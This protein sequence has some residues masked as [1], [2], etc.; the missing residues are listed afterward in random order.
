MTEADK[1]PKTQASSKIGFIG[2]GRMA[3]A[4]W[5]GIHLAQIYTSENVRIYVR[6][7]AKRD[8]ISRTFGLTTCFLKELLSTCDVLLFCIKPQEIRTFLDTMPLVDSQGKTV[9]SILAGTPLSVFEPYFP[10]SGLIRAMPNTPARLQEGMTGLAYHVNVS[11]QQAHIAR[12]LFGC[13]GRWVEV[14]ES[15]LNSVTAL[16]GSG[17]AFMIEIANA[18]AQA[19]QAEGLSFETSLEL[20]AQTMIGAG[21]LLQQTPSP[22][23]LIQEVC[24]PKG[25]TEAGLEALRAS[26]MKDILHALFKATLERANELSKPQ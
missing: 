2:F 7:E 23:K 21:K 16:S 4:I 3:K 14:A 26:N 12:V 10:K 5:A 6:D 15:Q 1:V 17:P 8:D 11:E 22:K 24:S 25:T 13:C 19:G 20:V 9:I 18:L